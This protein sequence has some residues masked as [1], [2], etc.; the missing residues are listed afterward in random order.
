VA[1]NG[2]KASKRLINTATNSTP[3]L[4]ELATIHSTVYSARV[5]VGEG[6]CSIDIY[7]NAA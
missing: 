4:A 3:S 2:A 6:L 7:R 1:V 5:P